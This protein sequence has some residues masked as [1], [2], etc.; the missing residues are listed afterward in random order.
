MSEYSFSKEAIDNAVEAAKR[1]HEE[2]NLQSVDSQHNI[3]HS[4]CML[5]AAECISVSVDNGNVCLNLPLGLGHVCLPIPISFPDG[6]AAEACLS[7]CTHLGVPTGVKVT[8]IIAG[9]TI[10]T[11]GFGWC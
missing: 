7:M 2:Q 5:V 9:K 1:A 4:G 6:T 10:I 11:K 3:V 8:I